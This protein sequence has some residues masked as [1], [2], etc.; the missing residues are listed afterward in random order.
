MITERRNSM[1]TEP[2]PV[3]S[4]RWSLLAAYLRDLLSTTGRRGWS[5]GGVDWI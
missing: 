4:T 2:L 3:L 1:I 5:T